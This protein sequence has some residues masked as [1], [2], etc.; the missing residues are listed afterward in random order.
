MSDRTPT[1]PLRP[2]TRVGR[3]FVR[4]TLFAAVLVGGWMFVTTY[5]DMFQAGTTAGPADDPVAPSDA[6]LLAAG[7]WTFGFADWDLAYRVTTAVEWARS[8]TVDAVPVGPK[9]ETE[10]K[11]LK[12]ATVLGKPRRVGNATVI[13]GPLGGQGWARARI[14]KHDGEDRLVHA[15]AAWKAD[16]DRLAVLELTPA[17]GRSAKAVASLLPLPAGVPVMA[18][19][20]SA[21]GKPQLQVIGPVADVAVLTAHW[22]AAGCERSETDTPAAGCFSGGRLPPRIGERAGDVVGWAEGRGHLLRPGSAIECFDGGRPPCPRAN[23]R[24]RP[25]HL[26][27][28]GQGC[29][30]GGTHTL[31]I[32]A[33]L[34]T[35]T[36]FD[37][38]T[39]HL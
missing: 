36:P 4:A 28:P 26:R 37:P 24:K 21:D 11:L 27:K 35:L 14:V 2:A 10:T 7:D 20:S 1:Q 25:P 39:A 17:V 5:R 23:V 33:I 31:A 9:S 22:S 8:E 15:A 34:A 30:G 19:R 38:R 16:G 32:L 29:Q 18:T 6:P 12:L 3:S 13:E